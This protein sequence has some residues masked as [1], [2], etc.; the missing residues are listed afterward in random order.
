MLKSIKKRL[1]NQRGLTLVELLAVIVILGI[2]AAIAVPNIG[3]LID[4]TEKDAKVAEGIQIINAA[5]IYMNSMKVDFSPIDTADADDT[6]DSIVIPD[7]VLAEYL[8]NAK[9]TDYKVIV[10]KSTTNGKYSYTL[11]NHES[12]AVV[13][14]SATDVDNTEAEL[15]EN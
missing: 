1:K 9:D 2:I 13:N 7:S 3:K 14:T 10:K 6:A 8:D 5:K 11:K 15:L 12:A 4:K